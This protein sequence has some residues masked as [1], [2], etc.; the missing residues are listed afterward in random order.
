MDWVRSGLFISV[1]GKLSW[2]RLTSLILTS[3][4]DVKMDGPVLE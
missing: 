3:A 2:L 1:L 4:I